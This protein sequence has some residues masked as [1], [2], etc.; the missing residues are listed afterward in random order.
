MSSSRRTREP[1]TSVAPDGS[2]VEVYR[3]LPEGDDAELVHSAISPGATVLDL[4]CGVGRI[5]RGLLRL[6][7][8]VTGVDNDPNMLSELP[9]GVE[10]VHADVTSV[11]LGR[12]FGAV[13]FAS[14]FLNAG[15][16]IQSLLAT[17]YAHLGVAGPLVAEV[18]PEGM[19]WEARVGLAR[20]I[21]SVEVTLARASV[22]GDLLDAEMRY[23][24]D[25]L[26]W[27][28]P[29]TA[30]LRT[31]ASLRDELEA[32]GFLWDRWIDEGRRWF[33]ARRAQ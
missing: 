24:I 11:R 16:E 17:A 7:H 28:Q 30:C 33:V 22:D 14:H 8:R 12:P 27:R 20:Q 4:G 29:F 10:G 31:E 9:R 18:Y 2:P 15:E 1:R 13:L 5:A 19:D 6:G 23:R 3:R 21:G 32:G 25:D 26:E